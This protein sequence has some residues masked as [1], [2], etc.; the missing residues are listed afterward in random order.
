MQKI[1]RNTVKNLSA[2]AVCVAIGILLPMVFHF[3]G[4][5]GP[6]FAPMH[7]PVLIC[8]LVCGYRYGGL[9]G[10]IVPLLSSLLTGMPVLYPTGLA[11]MLELCAYGVIGGLLYPRFHVYPSLIIAMLGGRLV[12]GAANAVL[13]GIAGKPYGLT[14]FLTAS[15]VTALPGILIQIILI[16]A[17]IL[18]LERS[19][20]LSKRPSKRRTETASI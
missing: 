6:V 11:M 18:V 12:S 8:G 2:A 1:G 7:I 4:G 10:L 20:F 13:L 17:L 3:F 19:G 16:P 14:T 9:C 5:T 15:F